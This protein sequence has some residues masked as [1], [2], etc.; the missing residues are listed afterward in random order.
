MC[1]GGC[2][3]V[4]ACLCVYVCEDLLRTEVCLKCR[5]NS[6]SL[7]VFFSIFYPGPGN[8]EITMRHGEY[9]YIPYVL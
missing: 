8:R 2:V 1:G 9:I 5:V 3:R 7:Y 6:V 4:R